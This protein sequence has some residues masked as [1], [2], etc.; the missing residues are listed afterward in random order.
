MALT[1][2]ECAARLELQ[3]LPLPVLAP[4]IFAGEK[5]ALKRKRTEQDRGSRDVGATNRF[6]LC[7]PT[8]VLVAC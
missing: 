7:P 4:L 1:C 5:S 2:G 6:V 3:T 8:S